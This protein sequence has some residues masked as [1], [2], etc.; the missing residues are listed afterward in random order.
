MPTEH[1]S[2]PPAPV[3]TYRHFHAPY[4]ERNRFLTSATE[5]EKHFLRDFERYHPFTTKSK[6]KQE[7][8]CESC[9][10][11][12]DPSNHGASPLPSEID[13]YPNLYPPQ[14]DTPKYPL[15]ANGNTIQADIATG[16][17]LD[18]SRDVDHWRPCRVCTY[19]V[20][21]KGNIVKGFLRP[22]HQDY[23]H[24]KYYGFAGRGAKTSWAHNPKFKMLEVLPKT[25]EAVSLGFD[26]LQTVVGG[27]RRELTPAEK[28]LI[29]EFRPRHSYPKSGCSG[30]EDHEGGP[31]KKEEKIE[32]IQEPHRDVVDLETKKVLDRDTSE[33]IQGWR[34]ATV[35]TYRHPTPDPDAFK[36][37]GAPSHGAPSPFHHR[38]KHYKQ[39]G[40]A[41][42]QQLYLRSLYSALC[43][44]RS[45]SENEL[46]KKPQNGN[47]L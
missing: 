33:E 15:V 8:P 35:V 22:P 42:L 31:C 39:Y 40:F 2:H 28:K 25:D 11:S 36:E 24:Y 45:R 9:P 12:S 14:S 30:F 34:P 43:G 19:K 4:N 27:P 17:P 41:G 38:Y 18:G 1:R 3:S 44:N 20:P 26:P 10:R 6:N 7:H 21:V 46:G 37:K 47:A 13:L 32:R 29:L 16:R 23:R 5:S